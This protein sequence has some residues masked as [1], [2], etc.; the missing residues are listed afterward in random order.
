MKIEMARYDWARYSGE[1][2]L[3]FP[4][5]AFSKTWFEGDQEMEQ[6]VIVTDRWLEGQGYGMAPF[7]D[8]AIQSIFAKCVP[9]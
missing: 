9:A 7:T 2:G 8:T 5:I 4:A 6:Q 1:S 3:P